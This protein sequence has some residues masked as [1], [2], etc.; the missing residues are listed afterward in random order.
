LKSH[1]FYS[2]RLSC[3]LVGLGVTF[4]AAGYAN[5]VSHTSETNAKS[6]R[7]T[8]LQSILWFD[9][10]IVWALEGNALVATHTHLHAETLSGLQRAACQI[11]PQG[12]NIALSIREL[13]RQAYLFPALVLM[14]PL[15]ERAAV[16][17]YLSVHHDAVSLWESGWKYGERPSLAKMLNAMGGANVDGGQAKKVCDAH[18]H[19]VHGDPIGSFSN[20]VRLGN[21]RAA[22]ASGK[23]TDSPELA[24]AVATEAQCYLIVVASRMIEVFPEVKVPPMATN[25]T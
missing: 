6:P 9:R 4:W 3:L 21:G 11:I 22:Y 17:S 5:A 23:R 20:L 19:I 1:Q 2:A 18:N 12:I 16:I 7:T 8:T 15:L 25:T 24:D 10:V 13:L 14:R